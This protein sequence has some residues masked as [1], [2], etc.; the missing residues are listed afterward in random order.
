[1]SETETGRTLEYKFMFV[2]A[3]I[4]NVVTDRYHP[5]IYKPSP[6]PSWSQGDLLRFRSMGN[7]T[8]GFDTH[9][10]ALDFVNNKMVKDVQN[11]IDKADSPMALIAD[12]VYTCLEKSFPWDGEGIPAMV[13]FFALDVDKQEAVLMM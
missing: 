1:M 10:E 11:T 2:I 6:Q 12:K 3:M 8:E 7:H 4:H 9:E 13:N 5:V